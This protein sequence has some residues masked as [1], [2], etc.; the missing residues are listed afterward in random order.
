MDFNNL[1][2]IVKNN[3]DK[4]AGLFTIVLLLIIFFGVKQAV[5]P[6]ITTLS[7]NLTKVSQKKDELKQYQDR[8]QYMNSNQSQKT[9]QNL[10]IKIYKAPYAG[11]DTESASVELVQEIIKIIK[12]AGNSRINQINF[13]TQELKDDSGTN[14][15]DYSVLSLNLSVEG[16]YESLQKTLNE[17][18]L[19]NYLVVIKKIKS[20]PIDNYNFDSIKTDLI[21]NLYIKLDDVANPDDAGSPDAGSPA[22]SQGEQLP[23]AQN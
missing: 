20:E 6:A 7:D 2:N 22:G 18:Y 3:Y 5:M 12:G 9:K 17:I 10:P 13:T 11:M 8:E 4:D 14:S 15:S 19:M 21:L 16:S 1:K 23:V